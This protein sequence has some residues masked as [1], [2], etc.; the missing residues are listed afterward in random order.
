M[1]LRDFA[2]LLFDGWTFLLEETLPIERTWE[3]GKSWKESKRPGQSSSR[4][5]RRLRPTSTQQLAI[6]SSR[7]KHL[8][9]TAQ[10]ST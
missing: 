4:G 1:V 9:L 8:L 6:D 2:H 3:P 7:Q 5:S 10:Q